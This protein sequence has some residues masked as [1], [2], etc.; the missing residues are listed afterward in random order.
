MPVSEGFIKRKNTTIVIA[1]ILVILGIIS[2]ISLPIAQLPDITPA[3]V[4][5]RSNYIG[6]N[7][8]TVENTVTTPLETQI[9]GVPGEMYM[10]STSANDGS[11]NITVTFLPGTNPDIATVDVQNRVSQAMPVI[12]AQ[13]QRTGVSVIKRSA[14]VLMLIA[15]KSP[16]NTHSVNFLSNYLAIFVEPEIAR[17]PGV[18]QANMFGQNYSMR[19]WLNPRKMATLGLTA[20]QV[21]SAIQGQSQQVP[22]GTVGAAPASSSQS[23]EYNITV[24]GQLETPEQFGNIIV[25]SNPQ[26]GALVKLK[27]IATL[28]LGTFSYNTDMIADGVNGTGMAVYLA[29]GANALKTAELVKAK[30]NELAKSFPPDVEWMMPF[31]TTPFVTLSIH[32]VI[33]TLLIAL[34]LVAFVVF[35]FLENW[36]A[37]IIPILV[38]PVSIIGAFLFLNIFGFSI[39]TLTLFAFVLAI[40]IVVDDAIVVVEATQRNIDVSKMLPREATLQAMREVQAP[41][42]AMSLILAAV[43]IP[44]AFIPGVSGKLY[45]QFALTIAFSVILSAFLALT[46][47]PVLCTLLLRSEK[48]Q[49]SSKGINW[50]FY[51]F[52]AWFNGVTEH[53]SKGVR[54]AIRKTY[55]VVIALLLIFALTFYLFKT[56]PTTFIP[57]EDMGRLIIAA[58]LPEGSSLER[59]QQVT[60][61]VVKTLL[62]DSAFTDHFMGVSGMNFAGGGAMESNAASF[63]VSLKPWAQRDAIGM[64]MS[65]A[66]KKLQEQFS[67]IPEAQIVVI[68]SPTLNGFGNSSGFSFILEQRSGDNQQEF[69]QVLSKFLAAA[70]KRPE[71][72]RAYD[73]YIPFSPS[74]HVEVDRS[75]CEL[76]GVNVSDVFSAIGT[77]MGGSYVNDFTRFD[78]EFHVLI[79]ADTAFRGSINDLSNYY[80]KNSQGQMVP[81]SALVDVT[82][83]GA[84]PVISHY[85]M[86]TSTEIDGDAAPGYSSGDAIN[87]LKQVAAQVLPANYGYEFTNISLQEI[88]A[89]NKTIMIFMLSILFVFLLLVALYESWSVPFAILLT[90]PVALFGAILFLFFSKQQ[91]SVYSQIGLICLI[92]LAAKNAILIVEYAKERVDRGVPLIQASLIAAKLR[93]RPILM[94]SFAFIF[95]V[96][97][98]CLA[99]GAGAAARLNIG[100]TVVGGMLLA[101]LLGIFTVPTLYVLIT[102][103]SY[104]RKKLNK[105]AVQQADS[106]SEGKII[107]GGDDGLEEMKHPVKE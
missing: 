56:V 50:F 106:D 57:Q 82:K 105:L 47:T 11:S 76:M 60:K 29:P 80:V 4:S 65:H 62:D 5:V 22:A 72:G 18:G 67:K 49:K 42:I 16:Q 19:V 81:L 98:L 88:E 40:G 9:N 78:R 66:V 91:D 63:W 48:F 27:D 73:F 58:V 51:H 77:F 84:P 41:I 12:P 87:A 89:G 99:T 61:Q 34:L 13:V 37:T 6:A 93:F 97:P 92:G 44:A 24:N 95:G 103:W 31:D 35:I 1:I 85:N 15:L 45:Q 102:R 8:K 2:I 64:D 25:S 43:F 86:Y 94:T 28:N 54:N 14:D 7:A 75:K 38:I 70:N 79:Q 53:Y 23:F 33:I 21:I 101:T 71:I 46:L 3:V 100:F 17:V 83:S 30:M 36:R 90:V 10:T 104:G 68:A 39:N 26:T 74:Y 55:V 59:T 69:E 107:G 20:D 52:T 96:L 32:E